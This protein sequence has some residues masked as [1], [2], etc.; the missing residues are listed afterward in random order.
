MT[1]EAPMHDKPDLP[2]GNAR[3]ERIASYAWCAAL[4]V[5]VT[6]AG[7][8][9]LNLAHWHVDPATNTALAEAIAWRQGT[10]DISPMTYE[11]AEI[12]GR[13]YNVVGLMF[14]IISA[15][16]V[17]LTQWLGG[18]ERAFAGWLYTTVI[19]LPL[20]LAAFGAF[21]R[22]GLA[23]RWAAV[24]SLY[25]ITGT[26]VW[27]VLAL[28]GKGDLYSICHVLAVVGLLIMGGDLLGPRRIWPAGLGLCV[29]C[30]S[31][32]VTCLY[33][34]PLLLLAAMRL[35]ET[36]A[37][38][39]PRSAHTA[40]S[41]IRRRLAFGFLFVALAALPSLALNY[42]KFG[43]PLETGY[44]A[45]FMSRHDAPADREQFRLFSPH[46]LP[47]HLKAMHLAYPLLEIRQGRPVIDP[48]DVDGASIWLVSPLLLGVFFTFGR[49]RLD[50]RRAVL[51]A[52]SVAVMLVVGCYCT[53]S[54][55]VTGHY[56]YALDVIPIWLLV[57]A[58]H[59]LGP[60]GRIWT[61]LALIWSAVY[62]NLLVR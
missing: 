61:V 16:G 7:F 53:T 1:A 26:S 54:A 45:L 11:T 22:V 23:P 41:T 55:L 59:V 42:V 62:F 60:S 21:R 44:V 51:M 4:L 12:N 56:R 57:I 58:P 47:R 19:F 18:G 49:W 52:G 5:A 32:Q 40:E 46:N 29:A 8:L 35:A 25:L 15:V 9:K 10:F 13:H 36:P 20:P 43:H 33:A 14:T 38:V 34:A 27:P 30:W 37:S 48:T 2:P 3:R 31:R 39:S 17:Q 50:R 24:L 6:T 28:C